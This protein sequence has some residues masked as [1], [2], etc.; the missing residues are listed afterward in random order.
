MNTLLKYFSKRMVDV[1]KTVDLR[2]KT[3][4]YITNGLIGY[5]ICYYDRQYYSHLRYFSSREDEHC[6]YDWLKIWFWLEP[7]ETA[8]SLVILECKTHKLAAIYGCKLTVI[9]YPRRDDKEFYYFRDREI[10]K[11]FIIKFI[12]ISES[13]LLNSLNKEPSMLR[14]M[15]LLLKN[16]SLRLG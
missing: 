10:I 15:I 1:Q 13:S 7:E 5:S 3:C 12:N 2:L 8:V 6:I 11:Q 16:Y 9:L 4:Y 14:R